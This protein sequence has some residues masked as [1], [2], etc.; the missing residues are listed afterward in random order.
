MIDIEQT[1][2]QSCSG[3]LASVAADRR[4]RA[5]TGVL[6]D[7]ELTGGDTA[8]IWCSQCERWQGWAHI[9]ALEAD[10]R[11]AYSRAHW[12]NLVLSA[13]DGQPAPAPVIALA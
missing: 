12:R 6:A 2:C 4:P 7:V 3:P 10:R 13:A 9:T 8:I 11:A 5:A 1:V